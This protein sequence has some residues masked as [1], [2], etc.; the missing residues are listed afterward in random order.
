MGLSNYCNCKNFCNNIYMISDSLEEDMRAQTISSRREFI[1]ISN[2]HNLTINYY[3]KKQAVNKII[4]AYRE[5]KR[6]QEEQLRINTY[7]DNEEINQERNEE[8]ENDDIDESKNKNE[9]SENNNNENFLVDNNYYFKTHESNNSL[10]NQNINNFNTSKVSNMNEMLEECNELE[11]SMLSKFNSPNSNNN[12][13]E[14]LSNQLKEEKSKVV[15][16]LDELDNEKKK[17]E[18]FK[19]KMIAVNFISTDQS[20]NFPVACIKTDSFQS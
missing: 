12:N 13:T 3:I 2:N 19:E 11:H 16:L 10:N 4:N 14:N 18:L 8:D 6:N 9:I 1:S 5:Y 20:I 17:V 15:K 7:N